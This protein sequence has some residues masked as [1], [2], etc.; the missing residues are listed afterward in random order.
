VRRILIVLRE[1]L[2]RG[3]ST[4]KGFPVIA[5]RASQGLNGGKRCSLEPVPSEE[6]AKL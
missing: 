4:P 6:G 1:D 5:L 3:G 2:E